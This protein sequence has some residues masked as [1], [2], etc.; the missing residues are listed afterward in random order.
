MHVEHVVAADVLAELPDR[1]EERED[2]DVADG[3][4]D[5]GDHDVD[6][7]VGGERQDAVLDLVGDVRD[8]LHGLAEVRAAPLLGEHVL[9]DRA[10]GGVR[11]LR[12]RHVDEALVVP[13]VEVG[14]AAVVGDEHLAVLERVHRA[15]VD[16]DVRVELLHRDPEATGLEETPER[17]G[18]EALAEAGGN[19]TGHEDVL[20][21]D[22]CSFCSF[23]RGSDRRRPYHATRDDPRTGVRYG[24][25]M[26]RVET[27][28]APE[29]ALR[30]ARFAHWHVDAT[31]LA[32]VA[33]LIR[34]PAFFADRS[35]VF[36]D[37]VFASSALAMRAGEVPFRDVFS[38][39][40]PVFL[41]LLWV[42]DLV[43]FRTMDAP[44]VLAV[45]AG[46]L[47]TVAV[48]SCARRITTRANALLA[49]GLVTTS[50]SIL[51]VTVPVNADGPSLA[52][53]VLAV[54]FA[55]RYRDEPRLRTAVWMGLAAGGAVSIKALSVPAVVI[56]GLDRAAVAP[57]GPRRRGRRPGIA[58]GR[59]RG[60]RAAVRHR[61]GVGPVVHVPPG[62][63]P[64]EHAHRRARRKILDTLWDRDLLVVLALVLAGIAFVVRFVLRRRA[65]NAGDRS[66]LVV[67]AGLVLWI[68]LVFALLVWEPAMW[69][70]HIAH[71]VPP[72]ALLAALRPAPWSVLAV[73]GLVAA[74]FFVSNNRS[75]LWPDGYTGPEAALVH[76]LER[77]PADALV[78][79]DDPGWVW[80]SGHRP[81]GAFADTSYQ[82]IDD[83]EITK[84]SLV[85]AASAA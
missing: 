35:L 6:V 71:L 43:G 37:G 11:L 76:H 23:A 82:R 78:I 45:A 85:K 19:A 40:G 54:A 72:L 51:W 12:E 18:G 70:A 83:G 52:L 49:A 33:V 63:A 3:A 46:V 74:P 21:Q 55:L 15:R 65:G 64:G 26:T 25:G 16:V 8:H 34:L 48:Y 13:E 14:L 30:P 67:V 59:L 57:A 42:A 9:V 24:A 62:L 36:D 84:A 60:G 20:R 7:F 68:V 2:L 53:S 61:P 77:F 27:P 31:V 5:L 58:R 1:L 44:R 81:P 39:Q 73:A 56:A 22:L 10:G 50:G 47:L 17:R 4:T 41:P 32:V 79:S 28:A 80:R 38:S 66:L 69:R 75:I 29:P